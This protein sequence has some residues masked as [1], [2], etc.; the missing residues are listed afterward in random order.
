MNTIKKW[1]IL[2]L[3]V[4]MLL[5]FVACDTTDEPTPTTAE[6]TTSEVVQTTPP[7]TTEGEPETTPAE[8]IL[9][10]D[11]AT[12]NVGETVTFTAVLKAGEE[13]SA[14]DS[15]TYTIVD[16]AAHASIADNKLTIAQTA[17]NG[18]EIKVKATSGDVESNVVSVIV[19]KPL[20]AITISTD[21]SSELT[22]GAGIILKKELTPADSTAAV[23]WTL[24]EGS[25]AASIVGDVLVVSQTAADGATIKVKAVSGNIESNVL[26]FTVDVPDTV[27]PLTSLSISSDTTGELN[28]GAV[29][30]INVTKVPANTTDLVNWVLVEGSEYASMA[31]N[32]LVVS[33]TAADGAAIKVKAVSGSI[34]SNV[35]TFTVDVPDN[36]V[37]LTS[38][39]IS[40]DSTSVNRGAASVITLTK[41]PVNTTDLVT[42]ELIEGSNIATMADNIL[43][44]NQNAVGGSVIKVKAISGSIESNVLTFTVAYS[45]EEINNSRYF[46]SFDEDSITFDKNGTFAPLLN[47]TVYNYNF[48]EITDCVIDY[49]IQSGS[50]FISLTPNG[51]ACSLTALG[52]GTATVR[53]TIRGTTV[54]ETATV[55][56]IVPPQVINLP[57]VFRERPNHN[58]SFSM[59]NPDTQTPYT[60]PFTATALGERVCTDMTVTFTHADGSTGDAVATYTNNAITFHKEGIVTATVTSN[61]GSRNETTVSYKFDVNKGYNVSTFEELRALAANAN[62][63]GSLPINLVVTQKPV[64]ATNYTYGYDL[65]PATALLAKEAQTFADVIDANKSTVRFV[66]KGVIIN[67]NQHK[68]DASQLRVPTG[69][70]IST[71]TAQGGSWGEHT[72]LLQ[73]YPWVDG[74]A[75][76]ATYRVDIRDLTVV[77]NCP[78]DYDTTSSRPGGVYN[79]GILIG[80]LNEDHPANYYLSMSNVSAQACR[81]GMRLLHIVD[82]RIDNAK[83]DNCFSNGFEIGGSILTLN[84]TTYGACGATGIEIVPEHSNKAGT[85]RNQNQQV[86]YAGNVTF[87]FL[88]DNTT[89]YMQNY[90]I[91]GTYTVPVILNA[92]FND[93]ANQLTNEQ[94]AHFVNA[95]GKIGYVTFK[96]HD[97]GTGTPNTSEIIYP[98]FQSGGIINARDLPKDGSKDTTHEY[99][100]I[101][102]IVTGLGDAGKAY[103]YNHNYVPAN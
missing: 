2:C 39:S 80:D 77:G 13:T 49:T 53:A 26:T 20:T 92:A 69:D 68:I 63:T 3:A 90:T 54:T 99:I 30:L 100:E 82:G 95:E 66:N 11:K 21:A 86:T 25:D 79:R 103:F 60:L 7:A 33:Q 84:N 67:G 88:N 14:P 55:K 5:L 46:M 76:L 74:T 16:G 22:R 4:L 28:P 94:I 65:V 31:G 102:V 96:F 43:V 59:S 97:V 98:G 9:T 58:Y 42:W 83:V 36:R 87:T 91:G 24:V 37:P 23:T 56:V 61:S 73:V 10:A 70:E 45:Q 40:S 38:L 51:Y 47:V 71:Y 19:V 18:V 57:E 64:G 34:E 29:A 35:L 1:S 75:P 101:D 32:V 44:V 89:K 12:A 62:Y 81:V 6:T 8:L 27:I 15:V 78:I 93:T 52:H 17:S 48:E 50:E 72:A 85:N 41:T